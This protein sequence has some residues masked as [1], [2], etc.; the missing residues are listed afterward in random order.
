MCY[1]FP[2]KRTFGDGPFVASPIKVYPQK[3]KT[4]SDFFLGYTL[5]TGMDNVSKSTAFYI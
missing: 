1:A 2:F 3:Q 5:L 4:P